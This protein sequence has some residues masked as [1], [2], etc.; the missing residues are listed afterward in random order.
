[1][2]YKKIIFD[3]DNTILDFSDTEEKSLKRVIETYDLP[4]TKETVQTYKDINH[5]LWRK[6]EQGIITREELF[7]SRFAL[8]LETFGIQVDGKKVDTFFSEHL[9]E[10]Y[11]MMEHAHEL[12]TVLKHNGY[13]LYAG[14]N[15]VAKIQWQRMKGAGIQHFFEEVFISED[16]GVEKPDPHFFTHIFETL[17]DHNK[18]EFLM[19]GDS[20]TSDIK[21]ANNAGIDSVWY[22]YAELSA[23]T[24]LAQSTYTITSLLE[25]LHLFNLKQRVT[26]SV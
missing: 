13:K 3:L 9:G 23:N 15:G 8:F 21:G 10:G 16:I 1:M 11:E 12:M 7:S 22:N 6:L 19:V 4:Y 2:R 5:E 17:N 14:S 26:R 25:L 24:E 20:L 18:D